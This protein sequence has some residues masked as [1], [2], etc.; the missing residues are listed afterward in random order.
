M[1]VKDG[2]L[3]DAV[4]DRERGRILK[5]DS[6]T[7]WNMWDGDVLIFNTYHWWFHTGQ[8]PMY[9]SFLATFFFAN[10]C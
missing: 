2:Y 1:W 4:R 7:S 5:L 10:R 9:S 8:T 3:V 6:I